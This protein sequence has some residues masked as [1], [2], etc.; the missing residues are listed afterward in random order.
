[1]TRVVKG[2]LGVVEDFGRKSWE[3]LE[4]MSFWSGFVGGKSLF[5]GGV[6]P[7]RGCGSGD[8]GQQ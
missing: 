8:K 2:E 1:M 5:L 4:E 6:A 3:F 7:V